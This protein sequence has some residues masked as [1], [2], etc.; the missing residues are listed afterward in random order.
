MWAT[1]GWIHTNPEHR[2]IQ[3]DILDKKREKIW[4]LLKMNYCKLLIFFN[5]TQLLL[6]ISSLT[7]FTKRFECVNKSDE[8]FYYG[9]ARSSVPL[10]IPLMNL[11]FYLFIIH[12]IESIGSCRFQIH[13]CIL[14]CVMGCELPREAVMKFGPAQFPWIWYK[15]LRSNSFHSKIFN[16][17]RYRQV[18]VEIFTAHYTCRN[19][20]LNLTLKLQEQLT[21]LT[22]K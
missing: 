8:C 7:R 2:A 18:L 1:L 6:I 5:H 3:K 13:L 11:L 17:T 16:L 15:C 20:D 10:K 14:A 9:Q 4:Q 21:D 12:I 19:A 22:F